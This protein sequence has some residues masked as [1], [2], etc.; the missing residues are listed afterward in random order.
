MCSLE[1]FYENKICILYEVIC[2]K[3]LK[4]LIIIIYSYMVNDLKICDIYIVS[5]LKWY[6]I[7]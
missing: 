6:S 4:Y 3:F 5:Y 7:V 1:G 2:S